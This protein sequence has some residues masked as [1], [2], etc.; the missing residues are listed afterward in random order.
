[1][2]VSAIPN[3]AEI[4]ETEVGVMKTDDTAGGAGS[5]KFGFWLILDAESKS[6]LPNL[7]CSKEAMRGKENKI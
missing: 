2:Q 1:M 6:V 7:H 4:D 3:R 5:I